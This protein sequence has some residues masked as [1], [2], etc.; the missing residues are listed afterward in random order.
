MNYQVNK[1]EMDENSDRTLKFTNLKLLTLN[2]EDTYHVNAQ[3]NIK[4]NWYEPIVFANI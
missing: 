1:K 2:A 3:C 4:T